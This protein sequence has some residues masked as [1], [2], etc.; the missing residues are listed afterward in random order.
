VITNVAWNQT[1]NS[2]NPYYA[3]NVTFSDPT[4]WLS[5]LLILGATLLPVV[6]VQYYSFHYLP[7]QAD[8]I[9]LN[10]YRDGLLN[11]SHNSHSSH[12]SFSQQPNDLREEK[13]NMAIDLSPGSPSSGGLRN[14]KSAHLHGTLV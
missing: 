10:L 8:K 12:H 6:A 1:F 3:V 13:K 7:S 2:L 5:N 4:F 14:D 11:N 9:R